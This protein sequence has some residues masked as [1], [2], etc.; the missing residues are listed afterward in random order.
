MPSPAEKFF[1]IQNDVYTRQLVDS[2]PRINSINPYLKVPLRAHQAAAIHA[3][4]L[5]ETRLTNGLD[6]SGEKL[7]SSWALLGDSVGVGK[8]LM[9]MGHIAEMKE[10]KKTMKAIPYVS[11]YVSPMMF[12]VSDVV[13]TDLSEAPPLL[14]VPHTLFRQWTAYIK[15]Q[16]KLK[17]FL[18]PTKRVL[19][20]DEF[21]T[22][23]FSSDLILISNT[24]AKAFLEKISTHKIRFQRVYIDEADSIKLSRDEYPLT[25]FT[26][27][28]TASWPSIL[29]SN[30]GSAVYFYYHFL[31]HICS[32]NSKYHPDLKR[33]YRALLQNSNPSTMF[34]ERY[35][36]YSRFIIEH[37][38]LDHPL[39]G[40]TVVRCSEDFIKDSI[41]LPPLYRIN[42]LCRPSLSQQIVSDAIAPEVRALLHAGDT[43]T[44]LTLL[45][46]QSDEP[47]TVIQAVTENRMKEL[48]R[49]KKTYEFKASI[50]YSTPKAKEEALA[51]LT[52]KISHLEE[53]IKNIKERI[54]NFQH[55]MCPICFD[56][57]SDSLLTKCCSRIFCAT[58]ILTSLTRKLEC[59]LCRTLTHPSHLR[60]ISLGSSSAAVPAEDPMP[61]KREALLKLLR[62]NPDGKFLIFSRYDNPFIQIQSEIEALNIQVKQV[63]GT[64]DSIQ[65]TLNAF[66]K[67][68]V[69]CLLLNSLHAG[70]GL[71]ITSAT[72]VILLHKM[73]LD[74]EKQI[75][76]RAYR[77]GRKEP[78]YLY[79]LLHPDEMTQES[80]EA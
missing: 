69:K 80:S 23:L 66:S 41:S 33:A 1:S 63:K 53:Q 9:I 48:D 79:R 42:I 14:I 6:V 16:S 70:A 73:D 31:S 18:V 13:Y 55:E 50:S 59:P 34:H 27:L 21:F 7:F 35:I 77:M 47:L 10:K 46:V 32:E 51:N 4:D 56:E 30:H 26:W 20:S 75:T 39:R 61:K 29:F 68:Q 28:I 38:C 64:K 15:D 36:T 2:S 65:A 71:T 44:A 11:P 25:Q 40:H 17:P 12:S 49:L 19:D 45:G 57:P 54:E 3:M 58:C 8:S 5:Q 62:D 24:L 74:E 72:H 52:A 78:L 37:F 43:Q 22:K 67:G 60:K 76:G